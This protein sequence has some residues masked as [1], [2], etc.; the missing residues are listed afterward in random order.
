MSAFDASILPQTK[1]TKVE[2]FYGDRQS[3]AV[4]TG[5]TGWRTWNRP[6]NATWIYMLCIGGGAGGGGGLTGG[7]LNPRG[8]GAGGGTGGASR[9]LMLAQFLPKTLYLLPG[10]GGKGGTPG[11]TATAGIAAGRSSINDTPNTL[12]T[13]ANTVLISGAAAAQGGSPGTSAGG[14]LGGAAETLATNALGLYMGMAIGLTFIPG[15][16]GT[17]GGILGSNGASQTY[18]TSGLLLSGG[19]GAGSL[20][21]GSNVDKAGGP[22]NGAG[23]FPTLLG[24]LAAAGAGQNGIHLEQPWYST[25]GTGGGSAGASGTA[26]N[27]GNGS[28]CCGGGGGGPGVTGGFGGD[29]GP[30][31]IMIVSWS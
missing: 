23:L 26:A 17:A 24:G 9:M 8:G 28:Y 1:G 6:K 21:S 2:F 18:G 13:V 31:L 11:T 12:G 3:T 20:S 29:G 10:F 30:G 22:V 19:T 14:A 16:V 15:V 27:G 5:V 4:G 7:T 25:G